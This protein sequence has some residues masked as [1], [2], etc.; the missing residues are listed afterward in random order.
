[1]RGMAPTTDGR[2]RVTFRRVLVATDFAPSAERAWA[3]AMDLARAQ[4]AELVLLH[5]YVEL[6]AYAD[7]AVPDLQRVYDEQRAWVQ[8]ALDE[9]VAAATTT[10]LRAR[11][12]VRTGRAADTICES[13]RDLACDLIVV[14]TQGRAGLDRLV[15]GSVAERV[16]R[17]APCPV[18]VV[19]LPEVE[20]R[21]AA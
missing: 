4:S 10:G 13:A 17:H 12:L 5:A 11:A 19:K 9:R 21:E 14:G 20:Q 1:M 15:V 8:H 3:I 16:V 7:I 18:L 2:D 6:P